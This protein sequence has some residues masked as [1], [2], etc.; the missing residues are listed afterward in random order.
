VSTKNKFV[1]SAAVDPEH[2]A[3]LDAIARERGWSTSDILR[4]AVVLAIENPE[5][6]MPVR[7]GYG[8]RR[9]LRPTLEQA[10]A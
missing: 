5:G 4:S 2:V 6:L 1:L 3:R 9:R 8:S 7:T 10:A